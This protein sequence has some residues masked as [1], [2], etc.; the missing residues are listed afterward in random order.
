MTQKSTDILQLCEAWKKAA[1]KSDGSTQ[2]N[3]D[4]EQFRLLAND[5]YFHDLDSKDLQDACVGLTSVLLLKGMNT[6]I[7]EDHYYFW[8]WVAQVM[9][10]RGTE[11]FD[12]NEADIR[13]LFSTCISASL[14][15]IGNSKGDDGIIDI[16]GRELVLKGNLILAHLSFPLL[17]AILKKTCQYYVD[18]SGKVLNDFQI[19]KEGQVIQYVTHGKG[20][21]SVSSLGDLL[22]LL[23]NNASQNLRDRLDSIRSH[24]SEIDDSIDPFYVIYRWRNHSL[25]GQQSYPTIGGTVLNIAIAIAL[26]EIGEKY[27]K[28]RGAIWKK[29]QRNMSFQS[30]GPTPYR[31]P[32]N[33]YPPFL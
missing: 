25:H 2:I 30:L 16:N 22:T 31:I 18:Y 32:G 28:M 9:L 27:D 12:D 5:I 6:F 20:K 23:Y 33:Y 1:Y 19:N 13:E 29:V 26:D 4:S 11:Y 10:Y 8:A 24:I 17:E 15:R 21:K 3:G 7:V 14:A